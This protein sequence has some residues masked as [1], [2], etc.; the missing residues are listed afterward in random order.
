[1]LNAVSAVRL[2]YCQ[3]LVEKDLQGDLL[4][5]VLVA[6]GVTVLYAWYNG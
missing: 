4:A 1:V 3:D 6:H 2:F 5:L